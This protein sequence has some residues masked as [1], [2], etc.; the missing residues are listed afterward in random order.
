MGKA[1]VAKAKANPHRGSTL[2][3]FLDE[4]GILEEATAKAAK[5]V[6]ADRVEEI[7]GNGK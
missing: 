3:D 2:D 6:L 4:E 7:E 1:K 5:K